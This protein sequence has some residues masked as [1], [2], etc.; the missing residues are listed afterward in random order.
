MPRLPPT[1]TATSEPSRAERPPGAQGRASRMD[2]LRTMEEVERLRPEWDALFERALERSP[3][4]SPDWLLAW[5]TSFARPEWTMCFGALRRDGELRGVAPLMI[6][7][8]RRWGRRCRVL[9]FWAD[10][11]SN[12]VNF[13]VPA[14][15]APAAM[16]AI[17]S[18]LG[19]SFGRW[20]LAHLGPLVLADATTRLFQA[21]LDRGGWAWGFETS[22][23]SPF[24]RLPS[25]WPE[26]EDS[27]GPTLKG[28]IQRKLRRAAREGAMFEVTGSAARVDDVF[29]ISL[30]TWQNAAGTG[31]ASSAANRSFYRQIA[32]FGERRGMLQLAFLRVGGVA[33]AYEFNLASDGTL[34]NLK[35]GY[36]TS[37]A[38]LSPGLVLRRHVVANAIREGHVEMDFMG[39]AEPYKLEW[40]SGVR[41]HGY[42]VVPGTSLY[43]RLGHR[44]WYRVRP[45]VKDR[46]P[47][48]VLLKRRILGLRGGPA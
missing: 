8:E 26:M 38:T 41:E 22:Y 45:W 30:E 24:R 31:E 2:V 3:F 15:G 14:D 46:L 33:V 34:Y 27:L 48:L 16:G 28:S 12:R 43:W 7:S 25:T 42:L 47:W 4:V 1:V 35:L 18:H 29:D 17:V 9:R 13:L 11:S 19:S 5:W 10:P 39:M 6:R 36:R 21:E 44:V 40:A 32:E 20:D 37:R 23:A